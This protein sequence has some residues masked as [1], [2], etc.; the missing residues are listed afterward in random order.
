MWSNFE[1]CL[2]IKGGTMSLHNHTLLNMKLVHMIRS[3]KHCTL[4]KV[5]W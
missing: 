2:K 4:S 3:S 5:F 1:V